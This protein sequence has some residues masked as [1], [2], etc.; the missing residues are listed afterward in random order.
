MLV[1]GAV[2]VIWRI[3]HRIFG[4]LLSSV[5]LCG[6]PQLMGHVASTWRKGEVN[7]QGKGY[8]ERERMCV[9]GVMVEANYL[10]SDCSRRILATEASMRAWMEVGTCFGSCLVCAHR[11]APR[12]ER[13]YPR[14][15]Q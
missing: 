12:N 3:C 9:G 6:T 5:G 7:Q 10:I 1:G 2:A 4:T 15:Y 13:T 8:G 14:K 11:P